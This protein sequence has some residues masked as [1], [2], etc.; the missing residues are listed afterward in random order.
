MYNIIIKDCSKLSVPKK[1]NIVII[2]NLERKKIIEI[3]KP[4][5][6][7]LDEIRMLLKKVK[8]ES[9]TE[10]KSIKNIKLNSKLVSSKYSE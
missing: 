9:N 7:F 3:F 4:F 6:N 5:I 8:K 2:K 1:I 10:D